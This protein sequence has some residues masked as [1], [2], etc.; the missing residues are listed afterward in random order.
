MPITLNSMRMTKVIIRKEP[1]MLIKKLRF[2][3]LL[4]CSLLLFVGCSDKKNTDQKD[5]AVAD[6]TQVTEDPEDLVDDEDVQNNDNNKEKLEQIE[7]QTSIGEETQSDEK[8]SPI[9]FQEVDEA[10]YATANVNIRSEG[11]LDSDIIRVL[12]KDESVNRIGYHD[13]WSQVKI[14]NQ[15]FYI[16]TKYLSLE[17]PQN[18]DTIDEPSATEVII[19]STNH[20]NAEGKLIVIDAGHQKN[21]NSDKEPIGPGASERKPKVSSGTKGVATGLKEYELNLTVA[22]K[23][24]D[25]LESSG[26]KVIMIRETHDIDISN[27]ERAAVANDANADAFIRIHANGADDKAV[28]GMMTISPTKNNPYIADLYKECKELSTVILDHM[29]DATAAK[30]RGVWETDTMSGINWCEIP[31]T[32][33]EMGYMTNKAEDE[34]MASSEYQDKIVKGIVDGLNEYFQ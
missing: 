4:L 6:D 1:S 23:L 8:A 12:A 11:S 21:G 26:Y 30:S 18:T 15:I 27:S 14:D 7:T 31:V 25:A 13:E 3:S 29:A 32:I 2:I 22:I 28:S 16:A 33:I 24:R 20:E 5:I 9:D 17:E 19:D 34:L 10:V